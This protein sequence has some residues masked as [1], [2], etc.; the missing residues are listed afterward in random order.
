M[1]DG[2]RKNSLRKFRQNKGCKKGIFSFRRLFKKI[3][4]TLSKIGRT[5]FFRTPLK[6]LKKKNIFLIFDEK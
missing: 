5:T 3:K 4:N 6:F 1:K 2:S